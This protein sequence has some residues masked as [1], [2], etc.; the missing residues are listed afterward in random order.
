MH[1]VVRPLV[2]RIQDPANVLLPPTNEPVAIREEDVQALHEMFPSIERDVI[3]SV[4]S[5]E[6]GNLDRAI[7]TCLELSSSI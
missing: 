1:P 2:H 7:N 3:K 6:R 5:S 4:L